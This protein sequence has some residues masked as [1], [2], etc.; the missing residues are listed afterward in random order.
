MFTWHALCCLSPRKLKPGL[1]WHFYSCVACSLC[2]CY[3]VTPTESELRWRKLLV[4]VTVEQCVV[5]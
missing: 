5:L 1:S 3:T 4:I 2:P